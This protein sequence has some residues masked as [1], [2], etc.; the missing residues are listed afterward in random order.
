METILSPDFTGDPWWDASVFSKSESCHGHI[1]C[2]YN[3]TTPWSID[4]NYTDPSST[5]QQY[6]H[7]CKMGSSG[8]EVKTPYTGL[9][10]ENF[11]EMVKK[12]IG[13]KA[14]PRLRQVMESFIQ[15]MH[16]FAREISLTNDEWMMAVKMINEGGRMSDAKRNE[17]QLMCDVIGLES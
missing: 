3:R 4:G 9:L 15:H 2:I 5:L 13:P 12:S 17:G 1:G 16:D 7:T 14:N 10:G 8:T 11:T 6:I